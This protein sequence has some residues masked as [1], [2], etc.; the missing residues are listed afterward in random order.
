MAS[1]DSC[2]LTNAPSSGNSNRKKSSPSPGRQSISDYLLQFKKQTGQYITHTWFSPTV[3]T[4]TLHVPVERNEEFLKRIYDYITETNPTILENPRRGENSITEKIITGANKFRMFADID[5]GVELFEKHDLPTEEYELRGYMSDL[6][7]MYDSV[8]GE[9]YGVDYVCDRVLS[10]RLPYKIHITYPSV[11][12]NKKIAECITER[13]VDKLK[14]DD[15][16]ARIIQNNEKLVDRSVYATGLRMTGMHK[17]VMGK[18]EKMEYEW[19]THENIFGENTYR[20]CYLF[21]NPSNFEPIAPT[22]DLFKRSSIHLQ[23]LNETDYTT[24]LDET[25]FASL[26]RNAKKAKIT[27][28][29]NGKFNSVL[30]SVNGN[31]SDSDGSQRSFGK[32]NM[33]ISSLQH[34]LK[35]FRRTYNHLINEEK[36]K[37]RELE[38]ETC[39]SIQA[40][41]ILPLQTKECHFA[42]RPHSSNHQYLIVDKNGSRQMCY[43]VDC[44]NQ[45]HKSIVPS[46]FPHSVKDELS[47]LGV[48]RTTVRT[49]L[50][51]Q[52]TDEQKLMVVEN[53]VKRIYFYYP[54]N[55]LAIDK[56]LVLFNEMGVYVPIKDS[57]C[58]ICKSSHDEPMTYFWI[59]ETGKMCLRCRNDSKIS[60]YFPNPPLLLDANTKQILFGAGTTSSIATNILTYG[61]STGDVSV[62]FEEEPIFEDETL[63]HLIYE[64]LAATTWSIVKVIHHLGKY[65]FNCTKGGEWYAYKNHRWNR[66]SEGTFLFFISENVAPYYRRVRNYYRDNT[67][68]Q[69]L[70]HKRISFIQNRIIDKLT[71]INSKMDMIKEAKTYFYEEDYYSLNNKTLH[72]EKQLDEKRN[73]LCFTNGVYDLDL[74]Q[75][76]DGDPYDFVTFTTGFDFV[77]QSDPHK[78]SFVEKFFQDIQPDEDERRYLLLF[79][80]SM[81]HGMTKE[82]SFHIFTG[83][84][85][86]GKSLLRDLLMYTLGEYFMSVPANLLTK[87]RPGSHSP[88]PEIC[89]LK[90]IRAAIGSEP[91]MGQKINT[92]FLKWITGNDPLKARLLHKNESIEFLPQFKLVLL[93][94]D[95]PLMDST[96]SGTWR[97]SRIL[98]FP[99][100]FCDNPKPNNRYEKLINPNMKSIIAGC[101]EEFMLYLMEYFREY[102]K[103]NSLRLTAK[104]DRMVQKHKKKSNTVL[105]FIEERTTVAPG[106]GILLV[107]LYPKYMKFMRDD[108]PGEIPVI[109]S[110]LIEELQRIRSIEYSKHVRIRGR[111]GG[112]QGIKNRRF[113]EEIELDNDPVM[114]EEEML[115]GASLLTA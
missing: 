61:E 103:M 64:S 99:V 76:R 11:V 98:E 60:S 92:G 28:I 113:L 30:A 56:S 35:Y 26:I 1:N 49:K 14:S 6:V 12:V 71:T 62:D 29:S 36:I 90:G 16:F 81:L 55:E 114:D 66:N 18:K 78:R 13:F 44:K 105:Q 58:E 46:R 53:L 101:R 80:S 23:N 91:E 93:C 17:S 47:K 40:S 42:G 45:E 102:R 68:S 83:A 27:K 84:A 20:H 74:D 21:T 15:R 67:A 111:K 24:P 88:Q 32:Q 33:L 52:A 8:I 97:R 100:V 75:F 63:N 77:E 22:F 3:R 82:E 95:I 72:F 7:S 87:E 25:A 31:E 2:L 50:K 110:K 48:I 34:T 73:L 112:Q 59:T 86:N 5:F 10:T 38:D 51:N 85:A 9:I 65:H 19:R 57:W 37:F 79:L 96:D 54:K 4:H 109:K 39:G 69:E 94:N 104:V 41:I 89:N 70:Q 107:D 115:D 106:N 108:N 43:D